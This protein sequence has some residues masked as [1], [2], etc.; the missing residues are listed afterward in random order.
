MEVI[1]NL[2]GR[3]DMPN[4]DFITLRKRKKEEE[5][6]QIKQIIYKRN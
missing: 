3:V 2:H 5:G 1:C 6:A 4:V